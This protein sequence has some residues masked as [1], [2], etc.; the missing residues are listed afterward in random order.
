MV[1]LDNVGFTVILRAV[2]VYVVRTEEL[3]SF[4]FRCQSDLTVLQCLDSN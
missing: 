1:L 2:V 3:G 4:L